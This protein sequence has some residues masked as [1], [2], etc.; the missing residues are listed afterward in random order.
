M[1]KSVKIILLA[2]IFM[3]VAVFALNYALIKRP[4][5]EIIENSPLNDGIEF[6]VN[7]GYY[8]DSSTLVFNVRQI[9]ADKTPADVFRVLLQFAEKL[10]D[11]NFDHIK[12]YSKGKLKFT[13]KGSYFKKLGVEYSTQNPVYTIRTFPQNVY[14]P[15]GQKA[16]G[17]WT[18]GFIGVVSKQMQDFNEFNNDWYIEDM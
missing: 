3:S 1:K 8:L 17:S 4:L 6:S 18:G 5:I 2:A 14:K 15:D 9:A 11:K 7:Y 13:L 12:L 16:F 10:S